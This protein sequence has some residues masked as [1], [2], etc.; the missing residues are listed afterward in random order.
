MKKHGCLWWVFIG[1]W[2]VFITLPFRIVAAIIRRAKGTAEKRLQ[3]NQETHKVAGV[4]FRQEALEA[5]GTKNPDFAKTKQQ[6]QKDGLTEQRIYEYSFNPR[7]VE[8][9]PEPDNPYSENGNAVKVVVDGQH[10]GYIKA[11]SSAHVGKLIKEDRIQRVECAIGGGRSKS[12]T[13]VGYIEDEKGTSADY[14][15]ETD[16]I[17]FYASITITKK[18]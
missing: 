10:I 2:W 3:D 4:S 14:T 17:G 7:K 15:L 1:W 6:L 11:G 12:L 18:P 16:E 8:L 13:A 5:L 9:I